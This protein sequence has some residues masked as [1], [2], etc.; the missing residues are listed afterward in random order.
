MSDELSVRPIALDLLRRQLESPDA[1]ADDIL[2]PLR[3]LQRIGLSNIDLQVHVERMRAVNDVTGDDPFFERNAVLALE[4]IEGLIPSYA[5]RWDPAAMAQIYLP[6]ALGTNVL[7]RGLVAALTPSDLLPPRADVR[8]SKE[9]VTEILGIVQNRLVNFEREPQ[10]ADFYRVPKAGLTTRPAALLALEDRITLEALADRIVNALVNEL[11]A[12][13]I[14]PRLNDT[15]ASYSSFT[16]IPEEWEGDYIVLADIESF[17]ECIDHVLL[18]TFVASQLNQPSSYT[19]ALESFLDAIM[20]SRTGLPQGPPASETFASA[21]LLT[22]DDVLLKSGW[23]FARY[24]DDYLIEATSVVDGRRRIETLETLFREMGLRLNVSK[25]KIMRRATYL[26]NLHKPSQRVEQLH[27]EIR[28][29]AEVRILESADSDEVDDYLREAGIDEEVLWDLFYNHT[30]TLE[31]VINEFRNVLQPPLIDAYAQ[32]FYDT[33]VT[34]LRRE[35]LPEDM[36]TK[37]HDL[38]ECLVVMSSAGYKVN[39]SLVS[40]TLKWFPRLAQHTAIYLRSIVQTDADSVRKLITEWLNPISDTDWV[41][42]WL[43]NVPESYPQ[44]IDQPLQS[45]LRALVGDSNVGL[46][47]RTGAARALAAGLMLDSAS[48]RKLWS[49]ATA[50]IRSELFWAQWAAPE[51]YPRDVP[52]IESNEP[53]K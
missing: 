51:H 35:G 14:W 32:Y 42:A 2:L 52:A 30:T 37:E 16:A 34:L 13:V 8:L 44:L 5:L 20:T 49:E 18:A 21:Y 4:M 23:T 38:R 39:L 19:R 27:A 22:V 3:A 53:G 15:T 7:E 9:Q 26:E 41:T 31:E 40:E 1:T 48:Y 47:T 50:A 46:L 25:T 6:K 11:P 10:H 28:R 43:C 12:A 24:A 45:V 36:L 17:Y 29:N 33:A